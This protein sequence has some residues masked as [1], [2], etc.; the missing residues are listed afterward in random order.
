MRH[1]KAIAWEDRL[2]RVF[3]AID[4]RL[5]DRYGHLFPLHPARPARGRTANRESDGLFD[6]GAAFSAGFGSKIGRG[7]VV[8]IRMA[9]LSHVPAPVRED[10]EREVVRLLKAGLANEFPGRKL[11]VSRDGNVYKIHGD[12]S[13]GEA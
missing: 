3:D 6:V 2:K 9:T 10:I 5:E 1:P 12:L 13:L 11:R 4:D 7:Y 8:E